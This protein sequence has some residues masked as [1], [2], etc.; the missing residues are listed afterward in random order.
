MVSTPGISA[1]QLPAAAMRAGRRPS[2]SRKSASANVA[3]REEV[4][5]RRKWLRLACERNQNWIAVAEPAATAMPEAATSA[6]IGAIAARAR[7]RKARTRWRCLPSPL[8]SWR[9]RR[10]AAADGRAG[11]EIGRILAGDGEP[12]EAARELARGHDQ[13]RHQQT[14]R[15]AARRSC[16]TAAA[17]A[18]EDRAAASAICDMS[19]GSRSKQCPFLAAQSAA[20]GETR[21]KLAEPALARRAVAKR[22]RRR[23]H[24]RQSAARRTIAAASR[25]SSCRAPPQ[26]QPDRQHRRGPA[27]TE[28]VS[29]GARAIRAGDCRNGDAR[30]RSVRN[31]RRDLQADDED[32]ADHRGDDL[33]SEPRA[34]WARSSGRARR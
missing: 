27:T 30:H 22:P 29:A 17:P 14:P 7:R 19:H 23:S 3:M 9:A 32:G 33:R 24:D 4:W 6:A 13:H 31:D 5:R 20:V 21:R 34:A 11:D 26:A 25:T 1:S 15:A 12:G 16:A 28:A 18:A 10:G 8:R 2:R